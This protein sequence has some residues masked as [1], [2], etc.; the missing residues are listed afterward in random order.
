[1]AKAVGPD[2]QPWKSYARSAMGQFVSS[3]MGFKVPYVVDARNTPDNDLSFQNW[4]RLT[5]LKE[6]AHELIATEASLHW[7]KNRGHENEEWLM[8]PMAGHEKN[9]QYILALTTLYMMQGWFSRL[10]LV[11]WI[12]KGT[13]QHKLGVQVARRDRDGSVA[14]TQP[15]LVS[16]FMIQM[17]FRETLH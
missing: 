10:F 2:S 4:R 5:T 9:Y 8:P 16:D 3:V 13:N 15:M 11:V 14:L 12:P 17:K 1:M 7:H 6:N